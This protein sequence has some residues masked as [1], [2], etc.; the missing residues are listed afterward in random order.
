MSKSD[1]KFTI[2]REGKPEK[3]PQFNRRTGNVYTPKDMLNFE[4]IV[5]EYWHRKYGIIEKDS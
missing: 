1:F 4:G 2:P 5:R 3:K